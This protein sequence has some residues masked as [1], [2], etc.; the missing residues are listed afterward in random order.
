MHDILLRYDIDINKEIKLCQGR[1]GLFRDH[2][3]FNEVGTILHSLI[4]YWLDSYSKESKE[5]VTAIEMLLKRGADPYLQDRHPVWKDSLQGNNALHL[6]AQNNDI[7]IIIL[8]LLYAANPAKLCAQKNNNG[9]RPCEHLI[10]SNETKNLIAQ[11]CQS[12]EYHEYRQ[13]WFKKNIGSPLAFV[14]NR[15]VGMRKKS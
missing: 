6:A 14:R 12:K 11:E 7:E 15:E 10:A 9:Q 3:A 8:L 2:P 1:G 4:D 13:Q 5:R